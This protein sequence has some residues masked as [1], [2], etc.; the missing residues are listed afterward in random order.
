MWWQNH[1]TAHRL[2]LEVSGV[3]PITDIE[4]AI[5]R[6]LQSLKSHDKKLLITIDEVTSNRFMREFAAAYQIL[7][8]Q[9]LPVY[10]KRQ[11]FW[12]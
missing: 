9:D 2:G 8:R 1:L 11:I 12:R 5:S 3:A 10:R 7:I 6:M 4:V